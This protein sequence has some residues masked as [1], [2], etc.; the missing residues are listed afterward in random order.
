M[1]VKRAPTCFGL[2][3]HHQG[4]C[5]LCYAKVIKVNDFYCCTVH[6]DNI[7]IILTKECTFY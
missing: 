4:A 5:H 2:N 6:L 1:Y 3:N 7:K